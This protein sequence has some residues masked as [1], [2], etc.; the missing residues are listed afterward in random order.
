M[1]AE[2][3]KMIIKIAH[4]PYEL[5]TKEEVKKEVK[6]EVEKVIENFAKIMF[7][8]IYPVG[9]IYLSMN[10]AFDPN[11]SFS[12]QWQLLEEGRYLRATTNSTNVGQKVEA[13]LPNAEFKFKALGQYDM[14]GEIKNVNLLQTDYGY[15]N[16]GNPGYGKGFPDSLVYTILLSKGNSIYGNSTTVTPSSFN[17]KMW[18]RVS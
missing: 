13:G 8:K 4:K 1:E 18:K 9:S 3:I 12:G 15:D 11:V 2:E 10:S 14:T 16:V 6:E 17:V 7:D 5:A